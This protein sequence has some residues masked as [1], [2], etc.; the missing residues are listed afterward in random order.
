[1]KMFRPTLYLAAAIAIVGYAPD[2]RAFHTGGVAECEGCHSMHNSL[3]NQA[4]VTGRPQFQSGPY[5]LKAQDQSGTCL[6]CHNSPDSVPSSYHISTDS[7]KL[8]PGLPPVEMTPGGDF[9]WLKKTYS[10]FIRGTPTTDDGDR[11]GHNIISNDYGYT[12]D[13]TLTAAPGGTYPSDRLGCISCHDP[14]GRY[15]RDAAGNIGTPNG[16]ASGWAGAPAS[17][18]VALPIFNSGSYQNSNDPIAGVS[19]VGV[20]RLL[21]GRG[22]SPRSMGGANAF[23]TDPP[24][25]VAPSTYNRSEAS[26]QTHV[27]YGSGMSEWCANCHTQMHSPSY[28]SGVTGLRHPAG[29][30]AKLTQAIVDNYNAYLSSGKVTN[31]NAIVAYSTLA[32]FEL[33]KTSSLSDVQLLKT[34]AVNTDTVDMRATTTGNVMCLSCHRAHASAFESMTRTFLG[35]EFITIADASNNAAY[36]NSVTEGKINFGKSVAEQQAAYYGR[37]ASSFGPW[38][39]NYCNK[40]HAK[41]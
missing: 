14:H 15:R 12:Q 11:H 39:R 27:A 31:A 26:G 16:Q 37:P 34:L 3:E 1:M 8:G 19:A 7:S 25:A 18:T 13:K 28:S 20:Y 22:D 33:G 17:A 2:A 38:A 5:L 35:N 4:N 41:D 36:D 24:T 30:T 10:F 23:V 40:C 6:N 9:A 32:P 29:N 21:A